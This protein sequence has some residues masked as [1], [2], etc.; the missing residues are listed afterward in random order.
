MYCD[1]CMFVENSTHLAPKLG[2]LL[3][4]QILY[5]AKQFGNVHI[6][7]HSHEIN[8]QQLEYFCQIL[9]WVNLNQDKGNVYHT[10]NME[11]VLNQINTNYPDKLFIIVGAQIPL[12]PN[13][14][15]I[16]NLSDIDTVLVKQNIIQLVQAYNCK[17][18]AS[19]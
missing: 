2:V 8:N 7:V 1:D 5:K 16:N 6:I 4:C 10:N 18:S 17:I 15:I 12:T 13:T 19:T 9:L 11:K 14:I 3:N